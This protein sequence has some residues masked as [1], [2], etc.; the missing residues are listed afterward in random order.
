ME[1]TITID[2]LIFEYGRTEES[3]SLILSVKALRESNTK[4]LR[5]FA[6]RTYLNTN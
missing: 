3:D 1:K 4:Y 2:N 6:G 5:P